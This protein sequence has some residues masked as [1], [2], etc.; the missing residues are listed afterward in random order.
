M[1]TLQVVIQLTK[2]TAAKRRGAPAS[3]T[4]GCLGAV[5]RRLLR[6]GR[7]LRFLCR[8]LL[9]ALR[10]ADRNGWSVLTPA[11]QRDAF[12]EVAGHVVCF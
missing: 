2:L 12:D 1:E 5:A 3:A 7:C 9:V 10:C 6:R 4:L 8:R 11:L